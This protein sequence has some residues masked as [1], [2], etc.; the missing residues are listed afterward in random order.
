[1][2]GI[3]TTGGPAVLVLALF[4]GVFVS[5]ALAGVIAYR[6][7]VGYRRTRSTRLLALS[8]GLLLVVVVPKLTNIALSTAAVVETDVVLT[9]TA[10]VRLVGLGVVLYS[11]YA[12]D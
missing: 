12:T 6:A 3:T 10:L 1:M 5:V 8:V 2:A 9:V 4:T 11:I 7:Y